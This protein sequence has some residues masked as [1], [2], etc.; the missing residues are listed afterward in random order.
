M[1]CNMVK[2]GE[3]TLVV[4]LLQL[5]SKG[6]NGLRWDDVCERAEKWLPLGCIFKSEQTVYVFRLETYQVNFV[7]KVHALLLTPRVYQSF[8]WRAKTFCHYGK[9]ALHLGSHFP[10]HGLCWILQGIV[11]TCYHLLSKLCVLASMINYMC[12]CVWACIYNLL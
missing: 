11:I 5:V 3:T 2:A 1:D 7:L 4:S 8:P 6:W 12:V 9:Q 10:S